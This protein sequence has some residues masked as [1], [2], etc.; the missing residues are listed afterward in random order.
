MAVQELYYQ[1][2]LHRGHETQVSVVSTYK[3]VR[4]ARNSAE[5]R[6]AAERHDTCPDL[7]QRFFYFVRPILAED[8]RKAEQE[9]FLRHEQKG[10]EFFMAQY[11]GELLP[12]AR[13]M[14]ATMLHGLETMDSGL[15]ASLK[16][17]GGEYRGYDERYDGYSR[18]L[19]SSIYSCA[20]ETICL[21]VAFLD[22]NSKRAALLG[23]FQN[24]DEL[25][26]WLC[27]SDEAA[28]ACEEKLIGICCSWYLPGDLRL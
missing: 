2:W 15:S 11:R 10:R 26:N 16:R 14:V 7:P 21:E 17:D 19:C 4:L 5:M 28:Q 12:Y 1:V 8:Y 6:N 24:E 27:R 13:R 9:I 22:G 18:I 23:V 25:K 3:E 20:T